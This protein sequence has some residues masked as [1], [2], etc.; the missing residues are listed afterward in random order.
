MSLDSRA[1]D[2]L[3][4]LLD[5]PTID[6]GDLIAAVEAASGAEELDWR[7]R[8]LIGEAWRALESRYGRDSLARHLRSKDPARLREAVAR[9]FAGH[10]PAE[11]KFP[12]LPDRLEFGMKAETIKRFLAELGEVLDRPLSLT[13]GGSAALILV[14]YLH[15]HTEYLDL[16][17]EVPPEIRRERGTLCDLARRFGLRLAHF[18]THYLPP[19]WASRTTTGGSYGKILL[20]LIDPYDIVAGKVFSARTRDRD[21]VRVVSRHLDR[22]RLLDRVHEFPEGVWADDRSRNQATKTWRLVFLEDLPPR[23][24]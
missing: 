18:Q 4:S 15:R 12:S 17:D 6:P 22:L 23:V 10:D 13:P 3:W 20:R 7:T 11:V 21:D 1:V 2:D 19:G 24:V 16:T 8:Q 9:V 5:T 14:G